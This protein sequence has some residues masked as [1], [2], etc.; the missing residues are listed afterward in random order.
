MTPEERENPQLFNGNRRLR[1]AKG[2]GTNITEVNKLLKQFEDMRK[3][4]KMMQ[5][6]NNPLKNLK[7]MGMPFGR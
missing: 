6:G 1:V 4:M 2:S 5:G 3:M 7:G